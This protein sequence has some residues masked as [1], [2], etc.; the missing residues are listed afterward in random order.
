MRGFQIEDRDGDFDENDEPSLKRKIREEMIGKLAS[1]WNEYHTRLE[2]RSWRSQEDR[3]EEAGYL[4]EM[5]EEYAS[6]KMAKFIESG[7][8]SFSE[9]DLF[10]FYKRNSNLPEEIRAEIGK[11]ERKF[12]DEFYA[13][14]K[15]KNSEDALRIQVIEELLSDLGGRMMR[16]YEHWNEEEHIREYMERDRDYE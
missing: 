2:H 3:D 6:D 15:E 16:P 13:K 8:A 10:E 7:N 4:S 11:M 5:A 14:Q 1:E 12:L 9:D